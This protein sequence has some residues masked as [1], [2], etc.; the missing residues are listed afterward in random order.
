MNRWPR[1]GAL[2][3]ER[4]ILFH[5]DAVQAVGQIPIN[6][7]EMNIDLLSLSAHKFNGPKGVGA[8]YA[9]RGVSLEP[10]YRGGGQERKLRPGTENVAGIVGLGRALELAVEEMPEK[11]GASRSCATALSRG[12]SEWAMWSSTGT[13]RP[14]CPAM[15][16]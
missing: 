7:R 3:R 6:V 11:A 4:G 8:L 13:P 5:T 9:R 14:A 10:L 15:S 1:S 12:F 16:M 2:A